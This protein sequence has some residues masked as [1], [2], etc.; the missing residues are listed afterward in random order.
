[1]TTPQTSL[2]NTTIIRE[3]KHISKYLIT[4][5]EITVDA[6][7]KYPNKETLY[8]QIV[9]GDSTIIP[10]VVRMVLDYQEITKF[11]PPEEQEYWARRSAV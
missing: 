2:P 10:A 3:I 1:M 8:E 4:I 7:S 6:E 11:M 9:V 5:Q